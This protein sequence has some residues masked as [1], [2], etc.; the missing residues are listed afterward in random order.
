MIGMDILQPVVALMIWTMFVW[1]LM[2]I[3]RI[4][5]MQKSPDLDVKHLHGG[6]TGALDGVLPERDQWPAHN[7]N[8]LLEQPTVFYA[9]AIVLAILGAGDGVTALLA[10]IYMGLRVIH[11]IVQVT[12]NRVIVRFVL[13]AISSVVLMALIGIAAATVF[14]G[15]TGGGEA[16]LQT[17]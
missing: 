17:V 11:T 12:A 15:G 6:T 14:G 8:H 2:Y 9:A 5:A 7:Y 10:W 3:R 4:P 13:F 1:L 16:L